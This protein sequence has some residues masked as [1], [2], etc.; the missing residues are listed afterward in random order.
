MRNLIYG[1][2]TSLDNFIADHDGRIEMFPR[3]G[4]HIEDYVQE[5][6]TYKTVI[7]GRKTYEFG[8]NHGLQK[9]AAMYP[10]MKNYMYSESMNTEPIDE[11]LKIITSDTVG[12]ISL[13]KSMEGPP[14]LLC[15]GGTLAGSLM[16]EG[17]IDELHLRICPITLNSGIPLLGNYKGNVRLEV[18]QEKEF[19]N[20]VVFA[21][22]KLIK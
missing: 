7:M 13:M 1:V 6:M 16:Q 10:F 9:G 3:E 12:H 14:I 15:G 17:L 11:N 18:I 20:K 19:D 5:L 4:A 2:A 22:Y 8:Y 21:K